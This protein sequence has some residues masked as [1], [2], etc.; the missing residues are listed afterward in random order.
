M[1]PKILSIITV[2]TSLGAAASAQNAEPDWTIDGYVGLTS[3]YRDRGLSLSDKGVAVFGSLA[4]FHKNGL[5]GGLDAALIDDGRG[6]DKK[7]EFFAG[8]SLDAGDYIYDFSVELDGIH[9]DT[10]DYYSEFK[11][12]IARD[13]GLAFIRSGI[14]YAPDGRWNTP[15]VDSVYGY[16]DLEIPVPTLPDFTLISH[17]GYDARDKRSN[18]WDWSVGLSAFVESIEFNLR[19]EN[20]SLDQRIGTG[21]VVLGTKLYF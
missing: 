8:Y 21:A 4:V 3:D 20:S 10:S 6:G 7:T 9:G 5:Y 16:V 15:E 14:G 2:V 19:Y 17:I 12:S 18:L 13:F 11:V 1:F